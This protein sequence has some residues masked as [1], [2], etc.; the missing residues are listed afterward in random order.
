MGQGPYDHPSYLTRQALCLGLTTAG[1]GG[2]S[3]RKS[4]PNDMRIRNISATVQTAGTSASPGHALT[5]RNG[6]TSIGLLALGTATQNGT[7]TSGDLNFTLPKGSVLNFLNGTDATGV[8]DVVV[9]AHLDP[10][11][12]WVG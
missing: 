1:N 3:L 8:A 5:V 6:T 11:G 7:V 10:A 4:F 12:N 9:E 2:T